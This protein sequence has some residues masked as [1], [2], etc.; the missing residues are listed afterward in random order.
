MRNGWLNDFKIWRFYIW[1]QKTSSISD[2]HF[3]SILPS[4]LPFSAGLK[5]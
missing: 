4:S 5:I 2:I 3:F 1:I